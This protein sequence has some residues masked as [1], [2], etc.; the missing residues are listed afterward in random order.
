MYSLVY[1]LRDI[2]CWI[3]RLVNNIFIGRKNPPKSETTPTVKSLFE[4]QTTYADKYKARL[5][6]TFEEPLS[7]S[8]DWSLN[9]DSAFNDPKQLKLILDDVNNK[10]EEE[11]KRRILFENTPRGNVIMYYD[12]YKQGFAYY[13]D[14]S[15]MPYD[16]MNAVAMKYVLNFQCRDFFIDEQ[17]LKHHAKPRAK[18]ETDESEE[19]EKKEKPNEAIK[20]ADT[21]TFAKFKNYN[22]TTKKATGGNN[23]TAET[24][25]TNKFIH[26]GQTRNFSFLQKPKRKFEQNGFKSQLMPTDTFQTNKM[27]YAEYKQKTCK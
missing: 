7:S 6:A 11:W 19:K 16:I 12:V 14:Q 5:L 3:F 24:K 1:C 17:V 18:K 9:V 25:I 13:C 27:S 8:R 4:T 15:V 22:S 2:I 23:A 10:L 21:N 20:G 26:L